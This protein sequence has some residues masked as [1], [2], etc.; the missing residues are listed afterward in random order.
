[1]V[2]PGFVRSWVA[3]I[4]SQRW[5]D[6]TYA[7]SPF[8]IRLQRDVGPRCKIGMAVLVHERPEY[9]EVCLDTLFRT[10]L[11]DYDITFLIQ[12]DGSQDPRVR[13]L[14]ERERDPRFKIVRS[15]TP[16]GPNAWGA[17][18][19]KA[20]RRL[21]E[22][23]DFDI[24][25]SCD[26]DALFHPEWL[27]QTMKICLWAK[28]H[29]RDHILG[30]FSSFNSSDYAFHHI[31]GTYSS[32]YGDYVV[33]RRMGAL[34]YFY[35]KEDLLRL[36]FFAE[37]RDD[38]TGMTARFRRLR[39]R[40]FCTK[41]SYV[42]HIGQDSVLN[43]WRPVP[44][45][46]AVYGMHLA[47]HGWPDAL[48]QSDTLGYYRSIKCTRSWGEGVWSD[49]PLDVI[50][51]AIEK[52]LPVLPFAVQSI[53]Q[54]LRHPIGKIMIVAPDSPTMRA[55]CAE[56]KC[57]FI[58]EDEVLPIKRQ[59]IDYTVN[60]LDRS[61]WVLQQFIKLSGDA[62]S[63]R[64]HF[65][66]LDADTVLSAPQ[67]F[68]VEGRTV[69]LHSDEHH[70]AYFAV[71][72]RLFGADASTALSFVA[73]QMLYSVQMLGEMRH[74]LRQRHQCAWHEALLNAI[75]RSDVSGISEY[76]LYGQWMLQRHPDMMEREYWY[77]LALGR[78]DLARLNHL[79]MTLAGQ[80]RSLSFHRYQMG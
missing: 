33:K 19:N 73:H 1:M 30:P 79:T 22:L 13:E 76:E 75:D 60:G 61:G 14:I 16:K 68:Q 29:H 31:Y 66:V 42:E 62:L 3:K 46:A 45:A 49:V 38:E 51:P 55:A 64:E 80:Y 35:L 6:R 53:R 58:R 4:L 28:A 20:M 10:N 67:V 37:H 9:L 44:V 40:N 77:N 7:R 54:N 47:R 25:G 78:H 56:I 48:R 2:I 26:A 11:Y 59:D 5:V 74:E 52:D 69:F 8:A 57:T 18:F 15:Y 63:D 71:Y 32:P 12:D 70:S 36:G 23:D 34:N 72:K 17:A 27:D 21:L 41:T 24:L 65:Y 50:M 39:V 43:A